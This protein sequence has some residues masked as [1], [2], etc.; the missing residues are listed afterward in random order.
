MSN[1]L[2]VFLHGASYLTVRLTR[3]DFI[4]GA[5]AAAAYSAIPGTS[6]ARSARYR[7]LAEML[8]GELVLPGDPG[9]GRGRR[10]YNGRFNEFPAAIALCASNSDVRRCVE[11][12]RRNGVEVS[13]RSG[14]HDYAGHSTCEG[15]LVI[16]LAWMN[17]ITLNEESGT[18]AVKMG[19]NVGQLY[20]ELWRHRYTAAAGTC[21]TV[22][23]G[24]LALGGGIGP[25]VCKYGLTCDNIVSAKI[26]TADGSILHVSANEHP[27]LFWAIRG[28]GGNFGVVTEIELRA[29]QIHRVLN[30]SVNYPESQH[31]DVLKL[32]RD[33]LPSAP[34]ELTTGVEI[35]TSRAEQA[36]LS[37][38]ICYTGNLDEGA[39]I[40][41]PLMKLGSP[42]SSVLKATSPP[43]AFISHVEPFGT[44][45]MQTGAF[46]PELSD[47][48][49]DRICAAI[50]AAPAPVEFGLDDLR[51]ASMT[52]DG[53]FPI[54]SRGLSSWIGAHWKRQG[55]RDA[56][57]AWVNDTLQALLPFADGV[58]VNRLHEEGQARAVAAYGASYDRLARIKAEYDPENFFHR[59]QNIIPD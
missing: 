38:S 32:Y 8:D 11:F 58:Y 31:R 54:R 2:T 17:R 18:A 16:D 10:I 26:V 5:F 23:M 49:I 19:A 59:N 20:D 43:R 22:G 24:G 42:D 29:F 7:Q 13:V 56:A 37:L 47:E 14:G 3:R 9:Y 25:L 51:G 55:N 57:K 35:N 52:G 1:Q 27:D 30:G 50:A 44:P 4:A 36:E 12:A 28:G 40:V 15:G 39:R 48:V 53:A 34:D 46:F 45:M 21:A 33:F 41:A 6:L